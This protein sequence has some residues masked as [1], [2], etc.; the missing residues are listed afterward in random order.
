MIPETAF[1]AGFALATVGLLLLGCAQHYAHRRDAKAAAE[2]IALWRETCRKWSG[3]YWSASR[4]ADMERKARN[5]AER[6]C[7][8]YR[9]A[10]RGEMTRQANAELIRP[11]E[12]VGE[13]KVLTFATTRR[14][15]RRVR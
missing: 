11:D 14:G 5:L 1:L 12:R 10:F 3:L 9:T 6:E 2:Q 13:A 7:N 4:R 15:G 8:R